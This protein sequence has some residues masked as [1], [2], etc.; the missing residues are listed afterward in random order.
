M[1]KPEA[2]T[3]YLDLIE[4]LRQTVAE[5]PNDLEGQILL[6]GTEA[7]LQNFMAASVAQENVVRLKGS[8]ASVDDH[9]DHAELLILAGRG[10]FR[11]KQKTRETRFSASND[12]APSRYCCH[13]CFKLIAPIAR[14]KIGNTLAEA[15]PDRYGL[16][17]SAL[18]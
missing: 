3:A 18:R 12:H 17:P 6:A 4:K 11:Q 8:D 15:G 7:S 16:S 13:Y 5:R 14:L 10:M 9:F 1:D 2:G